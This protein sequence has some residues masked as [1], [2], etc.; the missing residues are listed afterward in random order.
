VPAPRITGPPNM[1]NVRERIASQWAVAKK[2]LMLVLVF[3]GI[4]WVVFI[5]DALIPDAWL[6]LNSFA[7]RPRTVGGLFCIA[8]APFLHINIW[9]LMGNTMGLVIL[10]WTLVMSGRGIF[11]KVCVVTGIVS[12]LGTWAF[13]EGGIGHEGASG[14]LYGMIGFLLARGWFARRVL[15]SLI[16]LVVGLT[17]LGHIF[18]LLRNDPNV[19]WSAHFWGLAG[20][21]VMAWWM[22][23]RSASPVPAAAP[24]PSDMRHQ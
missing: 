9:H 19:S 21:I 7:I 5:V 8:T 18:T 11:L 6:E 3:V 17:H 22:Y 1:F 2:H 16:A 15:W 24:K 14:V 20:G 10:G 23:G 4:L 13:G 12:G